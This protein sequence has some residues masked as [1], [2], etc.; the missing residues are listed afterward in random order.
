MAT[1]STLAIKLTADT[2]SFTSGVGNTI[3]LSEKLATSIVRNNVVIKSATAA[4]KAADAAV[5]GYLAKIVKV[6]A[7]AGAIAVLGNTLKRA[8]SAGATGELAESLKTV[9]DATSE[10]S[11]AFGASFASWA[12]LRTVAENV[13]NAVRHLTPAFSA[14]GAILGV[15]FRPF[16]AFLPIVAGVSVILKSL[17]VVIG[18]ALHIALTRIIVQMITYRVLGTAM[19][20]LT[21]AWAV[22]KK[23][24]AGAMW[25]ANAALAALRA[26]SASYVG[27]ASAAGVASSI[28]AG[29]KWLVV[30]ATRALN[31]TLGVLRAILSPTVLL[32]YA[33][34]AAMGI[35]AAAKW[36]VVGATWA[37]NAALTVL[38]SISAPLWIAIGVAVAAVAVGIAIVAAVTYGVYKAWQWLISENPAKKHAEEVKRVA[39][40]TEAATQKARDFL[41]A[42]NESNL[43]A[44]MTE[45]GKKAYEFSKIIEKTKKDLAEQGIAFDGTAMERQLRNA[46]AIADA[47]KKRKDVTDAIKKLEEDL[48]TTGMTS[49]QKLA[50]EVEKL[51]GTAADI[52]RATALSAEIHAR[53]QIAEQIK[54]AAE[55]E[56][57]LKETG[58]ELVADLQR[59][60]DFYGQTGDMLKIAEAAAKGVSSADIAQATAMAKKLEMLDAEAAKRKKMVAE[61]E[62]MQQLAQS[63]TESVANPAEKLAEKLKELNKLREAG[64]I[65]QETYDRVK[66]KEGAGLKDEPKESKDVG[67]IAKGSQ[68]DIAARYSDN[69]KGI[70]QKI[71]QEAQDAKRQRDEMLRLLGRPAPQ[72]RIADFN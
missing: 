16:A 35:W 31:A 64:L 59:R 12:N 4:W 57:R 1:I 52:E 21:L 18:I 9:R 71:L 67:A 56:Q 25:V 23:V 62:K 19:T 40:A 11:A 2:T 58:A 47:A 17:S 41:A 10:A 70:D 33:V 26:N 55:V 37:L 27:T 30:G 3:K 54:K 5:G 60:V 50:R 63:I 29:A 48:A 69:R 51:G 72:P 13:A 53:E 49:A 61:A 68:A 22:A 28:W 8:L 7:S 34:S 66:K 6:G 15:F 24:L 46:L 32:S 43:T 20:P 65:S 38:A 14:A 42:V 44:G 36:L 39:E 45:A